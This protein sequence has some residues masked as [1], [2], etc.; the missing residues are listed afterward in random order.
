[1]PLSSLVFPR[2]YW[3]GP[4]HI[5][6][7]IWVDPCVEFAGSFS[8]T[9]RFISKVEERLPIFNFLSVF[10][11]AP[12]HAA[13]I[14]DFQPVVDQ[15]TRSQAR[16]DRQRVVVLVLFGVGI[17]QRAWGHERDERVRIKGKF[18]LLAGELVVSLAEPVWV[19]LFQ[20]GNVV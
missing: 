2:W 11:V 14:A 13:L 15:F 18:V 12:V 5:G 3:N 20:V 10:A 6:P 1:M 8:I 7:E 19:F 17:E 9:N 16:F 4:T